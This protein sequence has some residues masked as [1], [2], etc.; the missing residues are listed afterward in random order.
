M[1]LNQR[2][3]LASSSPRRREFF[4]ALGL[5][6]QVR[7]AL[8][9][10]ASV[11]CETPEQTV[12]LLSRLKAEAVGALAPGALVV[13]ADTVVIFDGEVLGKPRDSADASRILRM[14]SGRTHRVCTGVTVLMDS[15]ACATEV[16]DSE[17]TMRE[18]TETEIERYVATGDPLDKAGAYAIQ[19]PGFSPV[20]Q[21]RGCYAN[22]M[23]LPLC[24]LARAFRR[25][26]R[27]LGVDVPG[28]CRGQTGYYCGIHDRYLPG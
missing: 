28:L 17:I 20:A 8:V 16:A 10:E 24:H 15:E 1:A 21:I 12:A 14:L 4:L 9:D 7:T 18:Y 6:F 3:V 2:I 13:A 27:P 26:D 25:L 11:R 22:V 19:H 5:D 23:G